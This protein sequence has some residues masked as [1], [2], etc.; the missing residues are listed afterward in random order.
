M[1]SP[2]NEILSVMDFVRAEEFRI[3]NQDPDKSDALVDGLCYLGAL[4]HYARVDGWCPRFIQEYEDII[5]KLR[6]VVFLGNL[7][8]Y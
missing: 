4:E 2:S 7:S 8:S 5:N 1:V 3:R 6:A